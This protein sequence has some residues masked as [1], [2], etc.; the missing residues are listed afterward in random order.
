MYAVC[1][2]FH[3]KPERMEAFLCR[4]LRQAEDSLSVEPD[5]HR[6]DV[7]TSRDSPNR[8]FLYELYS[9]RTAFDQHLESSHFAVF[10]RAVREFIEHKDVR[11]FET[12]LQPPFRSA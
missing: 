6:F 5:C 8:V 4:M 2:T 1:V 9:D 7:C 11:C 10:D 12:V 3:I